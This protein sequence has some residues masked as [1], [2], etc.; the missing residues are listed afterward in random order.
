MTAVTD[1]E[2]PPG[3]EAGQPPEA[4]GLAR[5]DVRLLV[6]DSSGLRHARF[7]GLGQFLS[8]GDVLVVNTSA[9]LAAAID[10]R[11]P[12]GSA[13]TVHFSTLLDDGSWLVEL[14]PPGRATGPVTDAAAGQR[15]ELAA[16]AALTLRRAVPRAAAP[17]TGIPDDA[18]TDTA[19]PDRHATDS[20]A[21]DRHATDRHATDGPATDTAAVPRLW[22]ARVAVEGDV[23]AYLAAHGRPITYAYLTGSWPLSAYQTVFAR[24]PGS[25]EMPSAG[26]PFSTDLVTSLV[27]GGVLVTPITL[28]TGVSSLEAGEAPLREWFRIPAPTAELVTHA[29]AAGRRVIAVGTTVTRALESGAAPDGTVTARQGWTSLVL[30]PDRPARAVDGIVTGWHAPGASHLSLLAAVAGPDLVSDAY[31]EA[32]RHRYRWH[33]FGDSCLLLR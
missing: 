4:R 30:G 10:G 31:A 7:A 26:R 5:D 20:P 22:Q 1:F 17:A 24:H 25:A 19:A 28:H 2:L 21:T 8:P 29:R 9:T 6:A 12:D 3:L 32:I 33:E 23:R 18:A 11:R 13:V 27:A 15:V 16:G 14:R